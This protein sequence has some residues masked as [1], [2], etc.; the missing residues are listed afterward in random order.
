MVL[1]PTML[2]LN[3]LNDINQYPLKQHNTAILRDTSF[4]S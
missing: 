1:I 3:T 2:L 4:D